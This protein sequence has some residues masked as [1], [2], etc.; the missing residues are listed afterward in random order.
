MLATFVRFRKHVPPPACH[1]LG[2]GHRPTL[3]PAPHILLGA[4]FGHPLECGQPHDSLSTTAGARPGFT[5]RIIGVDV[6]LGELT[7]KNTRRF[8]VHN[9]D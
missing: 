7:Y 4:L 5:I 2:G 1:H 8:G 6:A 9:L 3:V